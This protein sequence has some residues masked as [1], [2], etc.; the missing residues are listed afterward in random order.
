[1]ISLF[2]QWSPAD[3]SGTCRAKLEQALNERRSLLL[4]NKKLVHEKH[5]RKEQELQ[6]LPDDETTVYISKLERCIAA[7]SLKCN[8]PNP[9]LPHPDA[10][11]KEQDS[12]AKNSR[13]QL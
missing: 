13:Q 9:F 4:V 12:E 2:L 11:T 8:V 3:D 1:L 6:R 10:E 5:L 7:L